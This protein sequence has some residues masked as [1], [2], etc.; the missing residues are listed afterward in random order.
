[1]SSSRRKRRPSQSVRRRLLSAGASSLQRRRSP[2]WYANQNLFIVGPFSRGNGHVLGREKGSDAFGR[3]CTC[4][5]V[6][7]FHD[8]S[9]CFHLSKV[10]LG[11]RS[12]LQMRKHGYL[13]SPVP[14][15]ISPSPLPPLP[16]AEERSCI[17]LSLLCLWKETRIGYSGFV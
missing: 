6:I 1:M 17:M 3:S 15:D 16:T 2:T 14:G 11:M 12:D 9:P 7:P 5:R 8:E 4:I 13:P 10:I